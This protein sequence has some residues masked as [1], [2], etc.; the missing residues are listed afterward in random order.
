MKMSGADAPLGG[1]MIQPT[2]PVRLQ[3]YLDLLDRVPDV[4]RRSWD[5]I[6]IYDLEGRLVAG[7]AAARDLVGGQL[8]SSLRGQ[9]FN[10]HMAIDAA[11]R[12]AREFA[13]CVTSGRPVDGESHFREA[14]GTPIPV[15]VRLV[16]AR[17]DGTIVGVIGF[18]RDTRAQRSVES[19]FI[20]AEDQFR[21][22]FEHHPDALAIHDMEGRY[23]RVNAALT[24]LT[25]F[26]IEELIGQTPAV[27]TGGAWADG[28]RIRTAVIRGETIDFERTL[29]TKSGETVDVA[30]LIV[31]LHGDGM[32]TGFC[33]ILRDVT[34]ERRRE[35]ESVRE[36]KRVADLYRIAAA[37]AMSAD[38]KIRS[39]LDVAR[40][41]LHATWAYVA[42]FD[43]AE[44]TIACAAGHAP[45]GFDAESAIAIDKTTAR[46]A[47][48]VPLLVDGERYG[49]IGFM[50]KSRTLR[51]APSDREYARAIAALIGSA[52]EQSAR[53]K[54]LDTLA[55]HD[56]LTGLPNRALLL[57]R[58]E[59]ALLGARRNRRSFAVHYIDI[60]HFKAINDTYGHHAGD[61]VLVAVAERLEAALRDS[62][63][64]A[65][66]GGDEFV[67]LQPEIESP[68]QA[69][70]LAAKL[71]ALHDAP[72]RAAGHEVDV[73]LSVGVAVYP[74]TG[75]HP[76]DMLREADA[77]LYEVKKGGRDG[78]RVRTV[79]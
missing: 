73:R 60:D 69:E 26:T 45:A 4:F 29:V 79:V 59:R 56:A 70:E 46:N 20:R 22:L 51:L 53:E 61:A 38:E 9:H 6:A 39:A 32:V 57:D 68:S 11:R 71:V 33:G 7:N 27:L 28:E 25:G 16:P 74:A 3:D 55:F 43:G 40:V 78:Y 19:Q 47:I 5:A 66:I 36:S 54:R 17:L 42:R 31:P 75:A 37:S 12:S 30:G 35:R 67:V 52:L 48:D 63:T 44:M 8:A 58:L 24:R 18:A 14:D 72:V 15:R 65:R 49:T 77:T 64:V 1:D 41:E 62:D 50:A 2:T 23:V 13:R 21:S 10:A 76:V 34:D